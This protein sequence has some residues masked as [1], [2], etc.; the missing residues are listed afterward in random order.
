MSIGTD[1]VVDFRRYRGRRD[2]AGLRSRSGP[3]ATA[4][5]PVF[6]SFAVPLPV[7]VPMLWFPWWAMIEWMSARS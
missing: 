7:A 1:N 5:D 4:A 2:R 3:R 6:V